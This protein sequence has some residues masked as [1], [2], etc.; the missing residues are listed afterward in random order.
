MSDGADADFCDDGEDA[1]EQLIDRVAQALRGDPLVYGRL[2]HVMV[3]NSVVI[4]VGDVGD[5]GSPEA[6]AA[7]AS[8]VWAVPG[9]YDVCNR[10]TVSAVGND[11]W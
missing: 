8:R 3:Q 5:V 2:L 10:L 6:K 7:A 9:V 11:V 1:D 4:L